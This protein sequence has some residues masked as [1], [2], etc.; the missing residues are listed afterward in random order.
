MSTADGIVFAV[1]LAVIFS[2]IAYPM[3][4]MAADLLAISARSR[5]GGCHGSVDF[6][7]D[8]AEFLSGAQ[9]QIPYPPPKR[10]ENRHGQKKPC[11]RHGGSL[12]LSEST[13]PMK[14]AWQFCAV[15][16]LR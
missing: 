2:A 15:R 16:N 4:D 7:D 10:D 13:N 1:S 5:R 3:A 14:I 12:I 11:A 9:F 8:C 6:A